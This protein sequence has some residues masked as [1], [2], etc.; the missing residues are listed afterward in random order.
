MLPDELRKFRTKI[1]KRC[2]Q[3]GEAAVHDALAVGAFG[4]GPKRHV[5]EEWVR[6]QRHRPGFNSRASEPEAWRRTYKPL[7]LL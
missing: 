6:E 5:V 4:G 2:D 1:R 3:L 7:K